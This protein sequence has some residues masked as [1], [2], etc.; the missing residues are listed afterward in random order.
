MFQLQFRTSKNLPTTTLQ[1]HRTEPIEPQIRSFATLAAR[2]PNRQTAGT[3]PETPA[4][5]FSQRALWHDHAAPPGLTESGL[6]ESGLTGSGLTGSYSIAPGPT[7][8]CSI[9]PELTEPE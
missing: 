6:T 4:P 2:R 5:A 9:E 1:F 8:S 7:G 3:E